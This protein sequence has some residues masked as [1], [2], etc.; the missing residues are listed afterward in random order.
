MHAC[1]PL[2]LLS[3]LSVCVVLVFFTCVCVCFSLPLVLTVLL[4]W[5]CVH[6]LFCCHHFDMEGRHFEVSCWWVVD[7]V[8]VVKMQVWVLMLVSGF[9]QESI[10]SCN[11]I[12]TN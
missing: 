11:S 2:A 4:N 3:L 10:E 5:S 8:V 9:I 1:L 12:P 6:M 7:V